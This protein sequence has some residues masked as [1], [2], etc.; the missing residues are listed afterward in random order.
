MA[1]KT[2][3]QLQAATSIT[4]NADFVIDTG[5]VT[6]K[7]KM[8]IIREFIRSGQILKKSVATSTPDYEIDDDTDTLIFT[9][10]SADVFVYLP[11]GVDGK[12]VTVKR[13]GIDTG[14]VSILP[15][16]GSGD[17]TEIG[18]DLKNSADSVTYEF[19]SGIWYPVAFYRHSVT[20]I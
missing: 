16:S 10:G 19:H 17:L 8:S 14:E 7:I 18:W 15:K 20:S 13:K 5:S 6:K 1:K 4:D 3:P 11:K 9:P 2:I 12:Q